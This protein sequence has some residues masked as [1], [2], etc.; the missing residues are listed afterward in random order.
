LF[1]DEHP[2]AAEAEAVAPAAEV[3]DLEPEGSIPGLRDLDAEPIDDGES[4]EAEPF[5]A[6]PIEDEPIDEIE[7]VDDDEIEAEEVE[8]AADDLES[9]AQIAV[10]PRASMPVPPP[11]TSL[12][13]P[14]PSGSRPP[15]GRKN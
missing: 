4:F 12:P 10:A 14:P 8:D 6:E 2:A 7:A 13:P 9:L 15:P 5:E 3:H 1:S 11:R